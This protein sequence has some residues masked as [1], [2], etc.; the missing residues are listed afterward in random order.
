MHS[1]FQQDV[2]IAS[3]KNR[4]RGITGALIAT[5]DHFLQVLEGDFGPVNEIFAS[6]AR[7]PRHEDIQLVAFGPADSRL[8]EGWNMR[9]FGVF[10][11]NKELETQLRNKYGE[12]AGGVRFSV[13]EWSALGIMH[14]V[15]MMQGI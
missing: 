14:D 10:D 15:S 7:D 3:D 8:V 2:H 5:R 11:L 4:D 9:G 12:E 6:I 13:E 1:V